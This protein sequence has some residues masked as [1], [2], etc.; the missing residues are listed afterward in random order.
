MKKRMK[1]LKSVLVYLLPM[2]LLCTVS[3]D[4]APPNNE[5]C[6]VGATMV[7]AINDDGI[8]DSVKTGIYTSSQ[9]YNMSHPNYNSQ[10]KIVVIPVAFDNFPQNNNITPTS[11]TTDFFSTAKGSVKNY[12]LEASYYQFSITN[13]GV[14]DWVVMP[15]NNAAYTTTAGDWTTN[16]NMYETIFQNA[17][18]GINWDLTDTDNDGFI[19]ENELLI[20]VLLPAIPNGTTGLGGTRRRANWDNDIVF[21]ANGNTYTLKCAISVADVKDNNWSNTSEPILTGIGT[22]VHEM[23]H[24]FFALPDRYTGGTCGTGGPGQFDLMSDNCRKIQMSA[25]DKIKIGWIRPHI[26]KNTTSHFSGLRRCIGFTPSEQDSANGTMVIWNE[27]R[28]DEF[29]IVEFRLANH[30]IWGFD[31]GLPDNGLLISWCKAGSDLF[32]MVDARNSTK[33][34]STNAG[35]GAGATFNTTNVPDA[36]TG[37]IRF[38]SFDNGSLSQTGI[39]NISPITNSVITAKF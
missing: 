11:I 19:E 38:F 5:S 25:F 34:A 26:M 33:K 21:T 39:S 14:S 13:M 27:N 23:S 35:L 36:S 15:N 9:I 30:S 7:E 28:S 32:Y 6:F 16:S 4:P 20:V 2:F 10:G 29:W 18:A 8:P 1:L 22:L 3:C 12:F 37:T 17:A 24:G 31:T